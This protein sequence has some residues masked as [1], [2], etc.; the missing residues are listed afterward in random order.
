M[1]ID[2]LDELPVRF[3]MIPVMRG[4]Q[5][6]VYP[7][8][9]RQALPEI[10]DGLHVVVWPVD[11][12][13]AMAEVH[14][15]HDEYAVLVQEPCYLGELLRLEI[16]RIFEETLSEDDVESLVTEPDVTFKKV[17]LHQIG[18]RLV[19]NYVDTIVLDIGRNQAHQGR[20]AAT[21][22]EEGALPAA[23]EPVDNPRRFFET[24]VRLAVCQALLAPEVLLVVAR[25][26]VGTTLRSEATATG[27]PVNDLPSV[28]H[29]FLP[30][31]L[32]D[33]DTT[34]LCHKVPVVG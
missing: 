17:T 14:I 32:A 15:R 34:T 21:N 31:R 8:V 5:D 29:D 11:T 28:A 23:G 9:V 18:R 4:R 6:P 10:A 30:R 24:I 33:V 3:A 25:S 12:R 1:H 20:R 7:E 27:W 2:G 22:V 13:V 19:Y 26:A 16:A